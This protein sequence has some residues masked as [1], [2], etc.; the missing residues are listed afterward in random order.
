MRQ[1]SA[2]PSSAAAKPVP[3]FTESQVESVVAAAAAAELLI[4]AELPIDDPVADLTA[5]CPVVESSGGHG[6]GAAVQETLNAVGQLLA[7]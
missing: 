1:A 5:P 4:A 6:V 7:V 2:M 3:L